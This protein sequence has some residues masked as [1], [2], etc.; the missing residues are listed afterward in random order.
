MFRCVVG[1]GYD[2][3]TKERV[4]CVVGLEYDAELCTAPDGRSSSWEPRAP[5]T[6]WAGGMGEWSS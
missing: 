4:R 3:V 1:L 6:Q 2:A 5:R